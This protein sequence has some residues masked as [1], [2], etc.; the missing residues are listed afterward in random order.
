MPDSL[1]HQGEAAPHQGEAAEETAE[2]PQS[3]PPQSAKAPDPATRRLIDT[4]RY[5]IDAPE[6]RAGTSLVEEARRA[7]EEEGCVVL[8]DFIARCMGVETLYEYA[9]PLAGLVINV[10]KP[11]CQHPWHF[12]NNDFIVTLLTQKADG[13]GAFEYC[14]NLREPDDQNIPG[15]KAV[16]GGTRAPVKRLDLQAGDLQIFYGRNS[17]H[18]VTRIEGARERHTVILGYAEEPGQIAGAARTKR[19]FGRV[20]DAHLEADARGRTRDAA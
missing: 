5:A 2:P 3:A 4:D 18:R 13:G 7:L 16:L 9:D 6:S 8:R 11:G 15:V 1:P 14:P 10:L 19:L 12:D 20:S 17:L